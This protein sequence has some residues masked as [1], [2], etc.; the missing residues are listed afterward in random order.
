MIAFVR[1]LGKLGAS[2]NATRYGWLTLLVWLVA[3]APSLAL[4][5]RVAIERG[6]S[7]VNVG[8]S[9][10]AIVRDSSGEVLGQIA[11]MNGFRAEGRSKNIAL[12]RWQGNA[13]WIEPEGDGFVYIGDGWYRGRTLLVATGDGIAAINYVDLEEYLYSVVGGEMVPSWPLEALKAQAVAARSYVLYQRQHR[14]GGLYDVGDTAA[15]QV[16]HGVES[17]ARSTH[18]AVQ[19]TAGQV[20]SHN[21]QIIEAVYHASSGGH[22]ENVEDIWGSPKPYLRGVP[23]YDMG[24]PVFEWRKTFSRSD[25][26]NRLGVGNIRSLVPERKTPRDRVVSLR[27]VGDGGTVS[28]DGDEVRNA[29]E[30]RSTLFA[31]QPQGNNFVVVGRG[32]G[33]GVG[34]SQ[35]GAYNMSRQGQNYLQILAHYYRN[36]SLSKL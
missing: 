17:E 5:L 36:S 10:N 21:G 29:L 30:L 32:F 8:S 16:Y 1:I 4:E 3:I 18:A 6:V 13:F 15:W 23:D 22:T 34:L 9:T 35:W 7:A 27:V 2:L 24:T 11:A 33:H 26:S 12:D 31:I 25:L 14:G 20:L 19:A 28:M